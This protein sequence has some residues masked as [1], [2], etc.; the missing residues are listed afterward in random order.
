MNKWLAWLR[1]SV[2]WITSHANSKLLRIPHQS[3]F[4]VETNRDFGSNRNLTSFD[5]PLISHC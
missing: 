1:L 2:T 4:H 3:K 5:S